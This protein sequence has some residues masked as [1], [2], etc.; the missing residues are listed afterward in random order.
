[1]LKEFIKSKLSVVSGFL[2]FSAISILPPFEGSADAQ[3][4]RQ[5]SQEY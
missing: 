1:M 3:I 2:V 4:L 5:S